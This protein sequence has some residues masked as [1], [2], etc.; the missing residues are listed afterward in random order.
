MLKSFQDYSIE[1]SYDTMI[2]VR[3]A[4]LSPEY[5][6]TDTKNQIHKRVTGKKKHDDK[7]KT[8]PTK[9]CLYC[10]LDFGP[11]YFSYTSNG[12]IHF[13]QS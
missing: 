10:T 7:P 13:L 2:S 3:T 8:R 12:W 11:N 5:H 1:S 4:G 6:V 9:F